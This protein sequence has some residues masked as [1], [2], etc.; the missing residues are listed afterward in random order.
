MGGGEAGRGQ[1][2]TKHSGVRGALGEA[3]VW[4]VLV[5]QSNS[6]QFRELP[7]DELSS[8]RH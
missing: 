8:V 3:G 4:R 7:K 5:H 1:G 6:V 2:L